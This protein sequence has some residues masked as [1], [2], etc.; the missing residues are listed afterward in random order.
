MVSCLLNIWEQLS[1][2]RCLIG[3]ISWRTKCIKENIARIR[4]REL[5]HINWCSFDRFSYWKKIKCERNKT[6]SMY[7]CFWLLIFFLNFVFPINKIGFGSNGANNMDR[8]HNWVTVSIQIRWSYTKH[9]CNTTVLWLPMH[10]MS[11]L[12]LYYN[13]L[14]M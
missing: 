14:N 3:D 8:G 9:F 2:R 7:Q 12:I 4:I 1:G 11:F 10:V 5:I 6:K 13:L